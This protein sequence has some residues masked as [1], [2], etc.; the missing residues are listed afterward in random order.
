[1]RVSDDEDP[2]GNFRRGPLPVSGGNY[3]SFSKDPII[4]QPLVGI[5]RLTD[6]LPLLFRS[7]A[8]ADLGREADAAGRHL[9]GPVRDH[10]ASGHSLH[11]AGPLDHAAKT[12]GRMDVPGGDLL[13][14]NI[15]ILF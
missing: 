11:R 4:R 7:G 5:T 12:G 9:P 15:I 1:M 2:G 3:R 6:D 13:D 14:G 10:D 8:L